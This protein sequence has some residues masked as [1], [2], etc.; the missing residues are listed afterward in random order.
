MFATPDAIYELTHKK[1][2]SA[3]AKV[4]ESFGLKFIRRPDGSIALR[5][6]EIDA[7][8]LS[9]YGKQKQKRNWRPDLSVLDKLN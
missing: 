9:G 8:T 1:R 3:Q 6:D 5:Q 7:H 4:L 2:P